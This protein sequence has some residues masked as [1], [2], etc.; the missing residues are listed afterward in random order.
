M[1]VIILAVLLFVVQ[2]AVADCD[3]NLSF[4][5]C[6]LSQDWKLRDKNGNVVPGYNHMNQQACMKAADLIP[7]LDPRLAPYTCGP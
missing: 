3:P 4:A 7:G 1:I 5:D 2:P 6:Q